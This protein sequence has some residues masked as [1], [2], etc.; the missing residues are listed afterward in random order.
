MT[1]LL[2]RIGAATL[3]AFTSLLVVLFKVSPLTSPGVAI[4]LFFLTVFLSTAGFI[5]LVAY[6]VWSR[7][8]VEG[9]DT[10]RKMSVSL[11]E[12]LFAAVA[13]DLLFLFQILGILTWWIAGLIC[14]V[15]LLVE[16]ALHS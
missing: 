4:P 3:L 15:F 12:G 16:V 8:S 6:I 7:L 2:I 14:L 13:V 1:P 11:R 10:G 5:S 9:M